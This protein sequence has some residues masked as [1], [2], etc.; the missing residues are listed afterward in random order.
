MRKLAFAFTLAI[1]ISSL[2]HSFAQPSI[3]HQ[4]DSIIQQFEAVENDSLRILQLGEEWEKFRFNTP[5]LAKELILRAL[6]IAEANNSAWGKSTAYYNLAPIYA[7]EEKDSIAKVYYQKALIYPTTIADTINILAINYNLLNMD[8]MEGLY[9]KVCTEIDSMILLAEYMHAEKFVAVFRSLSGLSHH[10]LNNNLLAMKQFLYSLEYHESQN[11]SSRMADN[12][13]YLGMTQHYMEKFPIAISYY[14]KA[15]SIYADIG[16]KYFEGIVLDHIG[17]LYLDRDMPD[18]ANFYLEK[19]LK[20]NLEN[21]FGWAGDNYAKLG[22][23]HLKQKKYTQSDQYF[24]QAIKLFEQQNDIVSIIRAQSSRAELLIKAGKWD[25]AFNILQKADA[26]SKSD[27]TGTWEQELYFPLI[28]MYEKRKN[29]VKALEYWNKYNTLKD[30]VHKSESV[31]Q[32]HELL[33]VYETEKKEKALLLEKQENETLRQEAEL[34]S[35]RLRNFWIITALLLGMGILLFIVYRQRARRKQLL[36]EQEKR[37]LQKEV[38][39][40]QRELTTHT[41]HLVSKNKLLNEIKSGIEK[42]KTESDNK[43]P[44]ITLIG[45]IDNDLRGD[46]DWE[47]FERYFKQVYSDFDDKIKQAFSELTGN[48][49]RLATLMKMN[50]ST[51]EIAT[52][53][54]ISPESVKKARYRLRKKLNLSTDQNL[55]QFILAL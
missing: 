26:L 37:A 55:Q 29:Y 21:D 22:M 19:S 17:D 1:C 13:M 5:E 8:Y 15:I 12:F 34:S 50:L 47:N 40:Q 49:I 46:S 41:L 23:T 42:I 43:R 27:P 20:I 32:Q 52:I 14:Q 33:V 2:S 31:R 3:K 45:S 4:A 7:Y 28:K 6:E 25:Q 9:Q 48:E 51:K 16:E 39:F 10:A 30:S 11:D 36:Q 18:S 35:L 53:L 24:S 38:E 44:Y 54:N